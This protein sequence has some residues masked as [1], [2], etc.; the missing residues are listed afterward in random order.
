MKERTAVFFVLLAGSCWGI[1]G[2]FINALTAY[3]YTRFEIIFFRAFVTSL[4]VG[5]W[6]GFRSP[7]KL[8]IRLK[9]IWIFIGAGIISF[10]AFNICY[11]QCIAETGMSVAAVLLYTAP[12]FV[13]L[14]SVLLFHDKLTLKKILALIAAFAGCVCVTGLIGGNDPVTVKGILLGLGSGLGYSLYTIFGQFGLRKYDSLTMT[15]W[16]FVFASIILVPFIDFGHLITTAAGNLPSVGLLLLCGLVTNLLPYILYTAALTTLDGSRASII[17]CIEP[18]V[19]TVF[20]VFVYDEPLTV[21]GIIGILLV[22]SA[23][24]ILNTGGKDK[25]KKSGEKENIQR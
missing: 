12:I 13:M 15:F 23:V 3:G 1:I 18:I 20:G 17:A 24:V 14:F 21:L 8:K 25:S 11:L 19:A 2:L 4:C 9:D 7:S 10:V 16:G 6:L 22:L 5:I